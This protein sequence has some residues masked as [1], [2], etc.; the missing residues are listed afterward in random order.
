VAEG[1]FAC[2]CRSARVVVVVVVGVD[3]ATVAGVERAGA[4]V[5]HQS[6]NHLGDET[7]EIASCNLCVILILYGFVQGSCKIEIGAINF[8]TD[9]PSESNRRI[10]C[11]LSYFRKIVV[12]EK[13]IK[14][15][16]EEFQTGQRSTAKRA[17]RCDVVCS[18]PTTEQNQEHP[19]VAH[20]AAVPQSKQAVVAVYNKSQLFD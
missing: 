13:S 9:R 10:D 7:R 1:R 19:T 16:E 2:C 5:A 8:W 12:V 20:P 4:F 14:R 17:R 15:Q 18:Q 11:I 6:Q 3:V